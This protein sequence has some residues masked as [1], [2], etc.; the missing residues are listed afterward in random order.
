LSTLFLGCFAF[1]LLF[2]VAS[3]LLGALG[4]AHIPGLDLDF[5]DSADLAGGESGSATHGGGHGTHVSPF[6]VS[7][8]SAFL[9]WFGGAGYLLTRYS[10]FTAALITAFATLAGL[11]GGGVVFLVLSRL[12]VPRLTVLR[13]E[14]FRLEGVVARVSSA[15]H[16]GG[17]GE[18]VYTVGGTRHAEGAR[19]ES[20][21]GLEQGREVVILRVEK[22]IAYVEPWSK[23]AATHH[24]P[25]GDAGRA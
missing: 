20:G 2:T 7:T 14:D 11:A 8:V 16:P 18:I 24:L 25:P 19:S 17:T 21:E 9:A 6:S 4:G 1:G 23:I 13:P 3:F 10:S 12:I 5:G 22:G 15:I